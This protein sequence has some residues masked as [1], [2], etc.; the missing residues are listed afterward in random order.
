[1]SGIT[2]STGINRIKICAV[3][4][5]FIA[6]RHTDAAEDLIVILVYTLVNICMC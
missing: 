5:E 3:A 4:F 1:M 6:N 2:L